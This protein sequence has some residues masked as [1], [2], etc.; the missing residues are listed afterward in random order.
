MDGDSSTDSD[1]NRNKMNL[2]RYS[3]A[4]LHR[5]ESDRYAFLCLHRFVS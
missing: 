3:E 5:I 1:E 4:C 2:L